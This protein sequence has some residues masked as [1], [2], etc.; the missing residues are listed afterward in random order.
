[1]A[2]EVKIYPE[3]SAIYEMKTY[4]KRIYAEDT[5]SGDVSYFIRELQLTLPL[6]FALE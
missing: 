3:S 5:E 1:M 6:K 4:A 2:S